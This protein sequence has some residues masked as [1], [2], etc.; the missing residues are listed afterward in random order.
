MASLL[1]GFQSIA[2]G[3]ATDAFSSLPDD[4]QQQIRQMV[5]P[6]AAKDRYGP[7]STPMYYLMAKGYGYDGTLDVNPE[8]RVY[9]KD[10]TEGPDWGNWELDRN[11]P[12]W[13][14]E[15]VKSW[16]DLGLNNTHLNLFPIDDSL[17]LSDDYLKAISDFAEL[18]EKHGLKVGIRL[19]ALGQREAWAVNPDNP[20]NQLK[21]YI[22]WTQKIVSIL[23]GK[24]VYW[25]LGDE[26]YLFDPPNVPE[27]GWRT[28]AYIEYFKQMSQ[29]IKAID[30]DAKV[31]M[32]GAESG[33][34]DTVLNMIKRGYTEYGDAVAINYYNYTDVPRFFKDAA[35]L[36]PGLL[37]LSNGV[38]YCSLG[39]ID[40]RYPEGDPYSPY[41]S[42][43]AHASA[44]A[45]NMFAWW[46]L[47]AS[48]AP[49]YVSLRNWVIDGRVY[50]RWFGFFGFED[51]VIE[52]DKLTVKH[53][54][55]WYTLR[56]VTHTFY[57][58]DQFVKPAFDVKTSEPVTM[59]RAYEHQRDGGSEL[60]LMLWNDK[61]TVKTAV[62]VD[63]KAYSYPVR[64]DNSDYSKWTDQPAEST[65]NGILLN[66][67]VGA[68]PVI[69]RLVKL[70]A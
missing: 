3:G 25:V 58:R 11:R 49:Y 60:L 24:T 46:D 65:E 33:H 12:D 20:D 34:W 36:A 67:E 69:I 35:D 19:D 6:P 22:E 43:E 48:T 53:Y 47:G 42:E 70:D 27:K 62:T 23:K 14:E 9:V 31:S 37:F 51:Y 57:N 1:I 2:F 66:L 10:G 56:T 68:D 13:Q 64:I 29:A 8:S 28:D 54:P 26:L 5:E 30:P 44:V 38:G 7:Y 52:N 55:A 17:E 32:F 15:M 59:F 40:Q 41:R 4:K 45:K 61:G 16:A 50:P 21:E 63:S 39:T 18:S